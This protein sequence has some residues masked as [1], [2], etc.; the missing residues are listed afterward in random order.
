M[1]WACCGTERTGL[2]TKPAVWPEFNCAVGPMLSPHRPQNLECCGSWF[3]QRG[4]GNEPGDS[5]GLTTTNERPPQ[6]P[7]NLTPSANRELQ[8]VQATMPGIRLE[9]AP[10]ELLPCDGDGLLPASV[11]A[12]S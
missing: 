11:R 12:L 10:L 4:H 3:E 2:V 1:R 5:P 6:R 9:W 7:Q 8:F